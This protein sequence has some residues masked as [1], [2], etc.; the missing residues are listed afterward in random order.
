MASTRQMRSEVTKSITHIGTEHDIIT[1]KFKDY[2]LDKYANL[3]TTFISYTSLDNVIESVLGQKQLINNFMNTYSFYSQLCLLDNDLHNYGNVYLM[4]G[5]S[6]NTVKVGRTYKFK[7]RYN[8]ETQ[9][10]LIFCVPVEND[11]VVERRIIDKFKQEFT[12]VSGNETFAYTNINAVKRAFKSAIGN[13]EKVISN[14]I[15]PHIKSI[16][17]G[18]KNNSWLSHLATKVI[19]RNYVEDRDTRTELLKLLSFIVSDSK[20][21]K[22]SVLFEE[23]NHQ[24]NTKCYYWKFHDYII[25]QNENDHYINGSRLYN[26]IIHT[27]RSRISMNFSHYLKSES[28]QRMKRQFEEEH[29]TQAFYTELKQNKEQPWLSGIYVHYLLVHPIIEHLDAHYG[30]FVAELMYKIFVPTT[31]IG[32]HVGLNES[33]ERNLS[34][35]ERY[36]E[37]L[38]TYTTTIRHIE[39]PFAFVDSIAA[40]LCDMPSLYD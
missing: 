28:V 36:N 13:D 30:L 12:L 11:R 9:T 2:T 18:G 29:P 1:Y 15:N 39:D 6:Q 10:K 32:G 31:L 34:G 35:D 5:S 22:K 19:I 14:A 17:M 40:T 23:Y 21:L 4:Y 26:S 27:D 8:Q 33:V 38:E 24:M 20:N 16:S 37:F 3:D 25:I 7:L